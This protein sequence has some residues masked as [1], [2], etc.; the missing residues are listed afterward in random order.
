MSIIVEHEKRKKEIL[1]RALGVFIDE[2]YEDTTFQKIAERCGITRTILYLYFK[3]KREIFCYSI[4]QFTEGLEAD[5]HAIASRADLS[6]AQ[7]L[8]SILSLIIGRC[9]Q[10]GPL[11]SIIFGYLDHLRKAGGDPDEL[12]RRRTIRMRHILATLIIAGIQ[13]GEFRKLPVHAAT[14]LLYSLIEAAIFR[15]VV[16]GRSEVNALMESARVAVEGLTVGGFGQKTAI[17]E[18]ELVEG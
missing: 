5:I 6:N 4:K 8:S 14:D 11:L 17:K 7:K 18:K 2:G 12:V 16:L 9:A 3:N 10:Q 1:D 13:S 15:V